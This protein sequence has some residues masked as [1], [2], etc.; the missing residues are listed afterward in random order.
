MAIT[1]DFMLITC[2]IYK[3]IFDKE[4][5]IPLKPEKEDKT[6]ERQYN[7]PVWG[8]QGGGLVREVN[9]TYIFVEKPDCPGL[10]VGDEMPE[11]W[12]I[13]PA[14]QQARADMDKFAIA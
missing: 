2:Y 9:G 4:K 14:N 11:M 12:G 8:T 10:D 3:S 6:M 1:I 13:I 5:D 7:Y